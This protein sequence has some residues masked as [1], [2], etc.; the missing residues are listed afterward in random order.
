M[1]KTTTNKALTERSMYL[2][3]I[4]DMVVF[5]DRSRRTSLLSKLSMID[6]E[7]RNRKSK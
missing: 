2:R 1:N 3:D 6:L 4:D 5:Q 7:L